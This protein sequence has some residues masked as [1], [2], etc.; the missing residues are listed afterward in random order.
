M[1]EVKLLGASNRGV[2]QL[3]K[4]QYLFL[5]ECCGYTFVSQQNTTGDFTTTEKTGTNGAF[6]GTDFVFTDATAASFV[7]GDVGKWILIV[8]AT[9]PVNNGWYKI[10]GYTDASNI[11]IDFRSGGTEYP[12]AASGLTWFIMDETYQ[13]T[14]TVGDYVRCNTPHA[15]GWDLELKYVTGGSSSKINYRLSMNADWTA[16]G[17]ILGPAWFNLEGG[18]TNDMYNY[19]FAD[20]GGTY[21]MFYQFHTSAGGNCGA[22]VAKIDPEYETGHPAV[23]RWSLM[24][25]NSIS[26]STSSTYFSRHYD[27]WAYNRVWREHSN[28]ERRSYHLD[29]SEWDY[30]YTFTGRAANEINV[31]TGKNDIRPG[32][33]LQVDTDNGADEYEIPGSLTGHYSIRNNVGVRTTITNVSAKDMIHLYDGTAIDWPGLTPQF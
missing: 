27:N 15:D 28:A 11:T 6:A 14:S 17:K 2:P 12:T 13:I 29:P 3:I 9:N 5:K 18:G 24:G 20:T 7:V 10:T 25:P 33:I 23:E 32:T 8:D 19:I 16:T 1:R 22:G 4:M 31:R 30:N 21:V 26:G